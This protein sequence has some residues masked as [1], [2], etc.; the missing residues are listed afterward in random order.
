MAHLPEV[1]SMDGIELT[2]EGIST[3]EKEYRTLEILEIEL[4]HETYM[5]SLLTDAFMKDRILDLEA[6]IAAVVSH[7]RTL[8]TA[9]F[10]H[11]PL[12]SPP[13]FSPTLFAGKTAASRGG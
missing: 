3:F 8:L 5:S 2:E 13:P 10:S 9:P 1:D 11:H 4:R 6:Q 7:H 12:F